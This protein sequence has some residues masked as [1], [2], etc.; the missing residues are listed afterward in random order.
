M[1]DPKKSPTGKSTKVTLVSP[2]EPPTAAPT[3]PPE[4]VDLFRAAIETLPPNAITQVVKKNWAW[5]L[6]L[7]APLLLSTY[8]SVRQI[9]EG[10]AQVAALVASTAQDH[11]DVVQVKKDI[12]SIDTKLDRVLWIVQ[13]QG[14]SH[15]YPASQPSN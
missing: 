9:V 10:P 12:A 5:V 15:S 8:Q 14:G 11:A 4:L 6:A 2:G 3:I 1:P 13:T 7:V